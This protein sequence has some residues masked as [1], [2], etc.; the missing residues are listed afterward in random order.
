VLTENGYTNVITID[1][2]RTI[3]KKLREAKP[4]LAFL[5][6]HGSFGEDGKIQGLLDILGIPFTGSQTLASSIGMNKIISKMIMNQ[7]G[8]PN[9]EFITVKKGSKQLPEF[10]FPCVL[11]DPENGSSAGIFIIN[12]ELEWE[13]AVN[14]IGIHSEFLC[15]KFWKGREITVAVLKN[16]VIGDCEVI[17][18]T[19]FYDYEAKYLSDETKYTPSPELDED[20]RAKLWENALLF[21]KTI[22]CRGVTRSDFIVNDKN[23]IMLEI[24]TLPGMTDHSLVPMIGA[25]NNIPILSIIET[26][27]EEALG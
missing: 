17:P 5:A 6:L 9:A 1:V 8:I 18:K 2:D 16:K 3:D 25:K 7:L 21:H 24:N 4:D 10:G 13:N 26:L 20:I 12:N 22:G 27:L 11:K 23:Y 14:K 15:E 19:G